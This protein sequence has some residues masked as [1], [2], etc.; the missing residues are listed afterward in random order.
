MPNRKK[1]LLN[2]RY[3]NKIYFRTPSE[4]QLENRKIPSLVE[5]MDIGKFY[6]NL[7]L[8]RQYWA[9]ADQGK[10]DYE[11]PLSRVTRLL[12]E[13]E[14]ASDLEI[15]KKIS[16]FL[17]LKNIVREA[18]KDKSSAKINYDEFKRIF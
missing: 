14:I 15:A 1:N 3:S 6:N 12:V 18:Q 5:Q 2:K 8:V 9:I 10:M 17:K 16:K 4:I 13:K 11:V 7:I